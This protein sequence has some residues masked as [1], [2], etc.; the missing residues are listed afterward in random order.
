MSHETMCGASYVNLERKN[1]M[2]VFVIGIYPTLSLTQGIISG[3]SVMG[4]SGI[5]QLQL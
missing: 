1:H 3:D 2:K 4:V 5:V